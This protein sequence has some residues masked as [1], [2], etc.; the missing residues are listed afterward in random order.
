MNKRL[1]ADQVLRHPWF[2]AVIVT[3]DFKDADYKAIASKEA[4]GEEADDEKYED[5]ESDVE[6]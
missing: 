6:S 5:E 1:T 3:G 2:S 4:P